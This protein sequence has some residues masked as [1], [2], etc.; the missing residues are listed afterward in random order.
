MYTGRVELC[1]GNKW[2]TICRRGWDDMDAT[3]ACKQLGF[4]SDEGAY[5]FRPGLDDGPSMTWL[6]DV[7]CTGNERQI[8]NCSYSNDVNEDSMCTKF[9][10]AGVNCSTGILLIKQALG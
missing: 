4:N 3:V 9:Q 2:G 8:I 1:L 5:A 10:D 6:I 7:H